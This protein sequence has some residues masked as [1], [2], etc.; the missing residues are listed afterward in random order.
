MNNTINCIDIDY[1]KPELSN[2]LLFGIIGLFGLG[3][4]YLGN[5]L[6]KPTIFTGGTIISTISSYKLLK[7]GMHYS[8]YQN[9]LVLYGASLLCGLIGGFNML[10][11][12]YIVNFVLG[13]CAGSSVGYLVYISYLHNYDIGKI[14]II[15]IVTFLSIIVPGI[16]FGL[17]TL[18]KNKEIMIIL[19]SVIGPGLVVFSINE[20]TCK[21][22]EWNYKIPTIFNIFMFLCLFSSGFYIQKKRETTKI[23]TKSQDLVNYH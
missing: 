22:L 1:Y 12:Y 14:W 18:K 4:T 2:T 23:D 3:I 5:K 10:K 6:I 21:V 9:C 20:F 16:L 7:I 11:W 15:D 8:P 19:T 17:Y 13:M